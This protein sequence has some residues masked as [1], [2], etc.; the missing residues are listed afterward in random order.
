[1]TISNE[2]IKTTVQGNGV[3]TTF[4]YNF[5][6]PS[7]SAAELYLLDTVTGDTILLPAAS[8]QLN[9]AGNPA[10]GTFLYPR[11]SGSDPATSTQTLTLVRAVP[12]TQNTNLGNQ[13]A[14]YPRAVEAALDWIVMQVQQFIDEAGRALRVPISE[15]GLPE[16]LP[17]AFRTNTLLSFDSAGAVDLLPIQP[18]NNTTVIATGSSTARTLATRFADM[19]NVLDHGAVPDWDGVTGTDN[20]AAFAAAF[21]YAATVKR[22]VFVPYGDFYAAT[23]LWLQEGALG[24]MM[25]GTLY[26]PGGF[27]ALTLGGNGATR[28]QNKVYGPVRVLRTTQSNWLSEADIGVRIWNADNCVCAVESAERFT[29]GLQL[30]SDLR[31]VEDSDFFL[32]R[33]I[34]NRYGVDLRT[35]NPGPNSYVNSNRYF[36]GHFAC[37]SAT[38]TTLDRFGVRLSREPGGYNLHN[39]NIFYGPAFELQISSGQTAIPFLVEV[40]ARALVAT[41]MRQEACSPYAARHTAAAND[42]IYEQGYVGTYG[43]VAGVVDYTATATRAGGTVRTMHQSAAAAGTPRLFADAGQVRS[44]AFRWRRSSS[45]IYVPGPPDFM[46]A[47][48]PF[49]SFGGV[50]Y[51]MEVGFEELAVMSGNPSGPPTNMSGFLFPGLSQVGLGADY[52]ELPTSRAIVFVVDTS[53]CKEIFI[54]AEGETLRPIVQQYDAG[55]NVLDATYPALFSNMNAIDAFPSTLPTP[56]NAS[57]W[58]GNVNLDSPVGAYEINKLQRVTVHPSCAYAA[59]GVRGGVAGSKLRSLRLYCAAEQ[60]P[61]ILY[62]GSRTWGS[63]TSTGK[64]TYTPPAALAAGARATEANRAQVTVPNVQWGDALVASFNE[65]TGQGRWLTWTCA[66]VSAGASGVVEATCTNSRDAAAITPNAG[67]VFVQATKPRL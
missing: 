37:S 35:F 39:Q 21:A 20:T 30:A 2:S 4:S 10:G 36:G 64:L 44:R 11:G 54:A 8:W 16:L 61:P 65:N 23:A 59:I 58:E 1:M 46:S 66:A 48:W 43:F 62:G 33:I 60:S 32:G 47:L 24:I 5:L 9:D 52:V 63:R 51:V 29:I 26:S 18:D 55:E 67:T 45:T 49:E 13:N 27:V 57:W 14:Y 53:R 28:N 41:Q 40:D 22:M 25:Q 3:Q 15:Q 19:V 34:D 6:I 42:C 17:A 7:A 31:G 56:S 50:D 38:N 12:Y